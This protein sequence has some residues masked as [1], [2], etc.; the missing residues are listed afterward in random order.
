MFHG[1]QTYVA[2]GYDDRTVHEVVT[3]FQT[4]VTAK[5]VINLV[6]VLNFQLDT[7]FPFIANTQKRSWSGVG[8]VT[9]Q[10]AA[11]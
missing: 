11:A 9:S 4:L 2:V 8:G 7:E 5:H 10:F 6:I 3:H 1:F